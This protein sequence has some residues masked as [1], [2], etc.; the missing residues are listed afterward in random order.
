MISVAPKLRVPRQ[1]RSRETLRRILDAFEAAL[2]NQTFEEVTVGELCERAGCSVGTFYGRVESKDALLEHLR[3]RVYSNVTERLRE[4]FDPQRG[5]DRDL[6]DTINEQC[7]VLLD[8]HLERRGVIR[9]V[10]LQAR[11]HPVFAEQT[12][13]FNG[14]ALTLARESWLQHRDEIVHD[15]P[16]LAAEQAALMISGYFREA[17]V[18][19]ELWPTQRTADRTDLLNQTRNMLVRFLMGRAPRKIE[20]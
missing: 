13:I 18:F 17:V 8:F 14:A 9:A 4:L 3:Q 12:Q 10:I 11:R 15:D 16:I 7:E 2:E 19:R 20:Q 6:E 1:Q 5:A